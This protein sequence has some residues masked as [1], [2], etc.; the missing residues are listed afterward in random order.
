MS[1]PGSCETNQSDAPADQPGLL[2]IQAIVHDDRFH[3][4][5]GGHVEAGKEGPT[6]AQPVAGNGPDGI[7]RDGSIA[8]KEGAAARPPSLSEAEPLRERLR[9]RRRLPISTYRLQFHRGFTFQKATAVVPYLAELGITD[10]YCSPYLQARPGSMHGYDITDHNRLNAELGTEADYDA[11]T[12]ALSQHR[13]GQVLDFV[14]NHMGV[15]PVTNHWWRDVL[16][17]GPSS[18]HARFFDIDWDPIKPE[19]KGKVLLPFLGDHYGLVLERGE[20]KLDFEEGCFI[21]RYFDTNLPVDPGKLPAVL[22]RRPRLPSRPS[23]ATKTATCWNTSASSRR[24]GAPAEVPR[25]RAP[26]RI[27]ERQRERKVTRDRLAR[28]VAASSR[29]QRHIDEIK[30]AYNGRPGE[31]ES[32][33][34]LHQLLDAQNLP[35]GLLEDGRPRNQLPPLLRH[36]RPGRPA[37]GRPRGIRRHAFADPSA[38]PRR[39]IDGPPPRSPRRPV[40]SGRLRGPLA[41]SDIARVG[42]G[43]GAGRRCPKRSGGKRSA[44]GAARSV[45]Q[46][47][48]GLADRPFWV[49]A[50]KILSAG[51]TLPAGVAPVWHQRLRFHE[52]SQSPVRRSVQRRRLKQVFSRFTQ[53]A[54][55]IT[56]VIYECKKLITWT[57]LGSE[58]NVL[59]FALNRMSEADRRL[60]DFTLAS[61]TE[62]LREVVAAF[63]VYRT[64]VSA[65]GAAEADRQIIELAL[66]R[67]RRRNP[68]ME[69]SVFRFLRGGVAA[70]EER[71]S[72][73]R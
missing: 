13:M 38:D 50:E 43:P 12:N 26:E 33:D 21:L 36:Q 3:A 69:P 61:L 54:G 58:L 44:N 48:G 66:R 42:R 64:Y 39:E 7:R 18:P 8:M 51:E 10:C 6:P 31:R 24:S 47:P 25:N 35:P 11:F 17:D 62:A 29:L 46:D 1:H 52:R 63:P 72:F 4:P 30:A 14:P 53:Q 32:F 28:L 34:R 41:G 5:G 71:G 45:V 73:R 19:L 65:A 59:A 60:R 49:V 67:A 20:L 56:A 68:A 22:A 9:S 37:Y 16:E 70:R 23:W 15:D 55:P 40:R 27:A 2:S 57:A